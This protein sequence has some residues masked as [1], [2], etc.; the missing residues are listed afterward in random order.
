VRL[1][2]LIVDARD[3]LAAAKRRAGALGFGDLLRTARDALRDRPEIAR[4]VRE[5]IDVLLVDEVQDTSRVQRGLGYLLRE[6]GD[7]AL[8]RLV[9]DGGSAG[10]ADSA[11]S[12]PK[13][14][15]GASPEARGLAACGLFLVGDRKQSIYGFRGA[16]VAVFSRIAAELAGRPAG[17]ALALPET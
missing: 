7:A 13:P 1:L 6:Q 9:H 2:A 12:A 15:A 3:R 16:D 17:E 8:A 4:A 5:E 10:S 11:G 14:P